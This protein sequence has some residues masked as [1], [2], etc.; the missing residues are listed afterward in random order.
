[1]YRQLLT[2][3]LRKIMLSTFAITA[4]ITLAAGLSGCG[5][6]GDLYLPEDSAKTFS[7]NPV[8]INNNL[9]DQSEL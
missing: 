1:M 8:S 3:I 6:K 4:A 7:S 2:Q 9:N 5:N